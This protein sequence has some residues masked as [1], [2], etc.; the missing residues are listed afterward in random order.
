[1]KKQFT[2]YVVLFILFQNLLHKE[3]ES[4]LKKIFEFIKRV[5]IVLL[6]LLILFIYQELIKGIFA[7][8]LYKKI[9]LNI[10]QGHFYKLAC[11]SFILTAP[12]IFYISKSR[13]KYKKNIDILNIKYSLFIYFIAN[14]FTITIV[15]IY[16]NIA[17]FFPIIDKSLGNFSNNIIRNLNGSL[18]SKVYLILYVAIIS[19]LIEEIVFRGIFYYEFKKI[20]KEKYVI[21]IT[22]L[23]FGIAHFNIVQSSYT[24]VLGL[25]LGYII[26]KYKDI[27]I[28]IL[29]H[30]LNNIQVFISNLNVMYFFIS[31]ISVIYFVYLIIRKKINFKNLL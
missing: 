31:I 16:I 14:F 7:Y 25:F 4:M 29:I 5:K 30:F 8:I 22:S 6:V 13:I 3:R 17:K 19:P 23:L 20:M 21:L 9:D 27:K 12:I 11:I 2:F 24:F 10:Y 18:E 26:Y 28:C 15:N 1:M